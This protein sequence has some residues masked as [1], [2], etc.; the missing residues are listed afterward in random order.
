[1]ADVQCLFTGHRPTQDEIFRNDYRTAYSYNG[2]CCY[3]E[4][5]HGLSS[6]AAVLRRIHVLPGRIQRGDREYAMVWDCAPAP[7]SQLPVPKATLGA[8]T[9]TL[10]SEPRD[11]RIDIKAL[12]TEDSGGGQ[13][14]FYYQALLQD[15]RVVRIR[16][17]MLTQRVLGRCGLIVC[18]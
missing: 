11:D 18:D 1:M 13:L 12:L 3:L 6:N 5:L 9:I 4:V 8:K 16:P 14:I 15:G 7:Q 10:S 2:I 17:G